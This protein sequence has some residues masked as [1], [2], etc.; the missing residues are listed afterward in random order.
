MKKQRGETI[1]EYLAVAALAVV[2]GLSY[3]LFV[4]PNTFAPAGLNG[5]ATMVQYVFRVNIGYFSLLVNL[6][7][8]F[9][10]WRELNPDFA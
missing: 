8:I 1:R 10:A 4:F 6:P 7:L 3:E 5:L 2:M 9:L